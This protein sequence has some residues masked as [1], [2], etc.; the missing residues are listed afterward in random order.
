[1]CECL[2]D[3]DKEALQLINDAE[4]L[5]L[6]VELLTKRL[7]KLNKKLEEIEVGLVHV[8]QLQAMKQKR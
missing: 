6:Q 4:T 7:Q 2:S 1:M 3:I 8:A 5:L